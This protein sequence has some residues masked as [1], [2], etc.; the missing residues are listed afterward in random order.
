MYTNLHPDLTLLS[1]KTTNRHPR[2]QLVN[3]YRSQKSEPAIYKFSIYIGATFKISD[4]SSIC[5]SFIVFPPVTASSHMEV[6]FHVHKVFM[7]YQMLKL[8]CVMI[9]LEGL[10]MRLRMRRDTE[11]RSRYHWPEKK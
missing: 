6:L 7:F 8:S 5:S 3:F 2:I 1:Q 10:L 4:M 9:E 11:L